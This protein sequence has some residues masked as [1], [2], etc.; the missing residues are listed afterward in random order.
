MNCQLHE[1]TDRQQTFIK[2]KQSNGY[3]YFTSYKETL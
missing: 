3:I 1:K 2:A